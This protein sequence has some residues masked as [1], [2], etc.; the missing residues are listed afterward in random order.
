MKRK[1]LSWTVR[2]RYW[3]DEKVSDGSMGMIKLLTI[4]TV[5]ATVLFAVA[6]YV[7]SLVSGEEQSFTSAWWNTL[8]SVIN[9]WLPFYGDGWVGY[10]VIMTFAAILACL[11]PAYSSVS[12]RLLW[13]KRSKN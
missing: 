4:C 2:L 1:K 11:L 5:M 8:A 10:R 3:L 9:K 7:I 13:R 12:L 6:L